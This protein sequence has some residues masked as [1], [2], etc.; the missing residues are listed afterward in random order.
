MRHIPHAS[1]DRRTKG[2]LM[3]VRRDAQPSWGGQI[4]QHSFNPSPKGPAMDAVVQASML[5]NDPNYKRVNYPDDLP[6]HTHI[7]HKDPTA[8][9]GERIAGT[10]LTDEIEPLIRRKRQTL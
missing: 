2:A 10:F 8:P 6:R 1:T 5:L 4:P 9:N 7:W 3:Q